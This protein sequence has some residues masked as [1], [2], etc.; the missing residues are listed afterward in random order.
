MVCNM[1]IMLVHINVS[2]SLV[3]EL[4]HAD[5]SDIV[6]HSENEMQGFMK[7]FVLA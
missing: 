2:S 6:A 1:H 7:R 5:D 4:L 3:R